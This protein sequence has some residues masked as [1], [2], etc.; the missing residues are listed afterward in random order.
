MTVFDCWKAGDVLGFW[1][2]RGWGGG[3]GGVIIMHQRD[4]GLA[5]L[6]MLISA[7]MNGGRWLYRA[8]AIAFGWL[9]V[10]TSHMVAVIGVLVQSD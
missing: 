5:S 9:D 4:A 8:M 1:G 2:G 7:L 3:G 10:G 6:C